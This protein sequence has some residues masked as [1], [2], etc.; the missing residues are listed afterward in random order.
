MKQRLQTVMIALGLMLGVGSF[1]A[2]P[3]SAISVFGDEA[4]PADSTSKVCA[5]KGET[6][7]GPVQ[8]VISILLFAVGVVSVIMIIVGGL[9]YVISNGDAGRIKSAKDT[10]LYSVVG[11]VVALLAFTIVNFVVERF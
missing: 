4:C 9:R 6:V 11:L 2:A 3:A 5:A 8:T 1:V 10:V 7:A